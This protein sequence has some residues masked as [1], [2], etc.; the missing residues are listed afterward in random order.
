MQPQATQEER[1]VKPDMNVVCWFEIPVSDMQRAKAFYE[2]VFGIR[3]ELTR[4]DEY[5][6]AMFPAKMEFSG[7]PGCLSKGPLAQPS[8]T[9]TLI[10]FNVT[11][12]EAVLDRVRQAG[13]K[14]CLDKRS[15]GKYGF[16]AVFTDAEGNDIGLHCMT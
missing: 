1:L 7:A 13:G 10:Y 4:M 14:V 3:L 5:E 2:R 8:S 16:I 15:I 6:M 12:I 11:S 9:G